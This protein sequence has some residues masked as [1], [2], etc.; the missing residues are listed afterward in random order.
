MDPWMTL[1]AAAAL[2]AGA[3]PLW[4]WLAGARSLGQLRLQSVAVQ[5]LD[6]AAIPSPHRG[7]LNAVAG[8][9]A[10]MGFTYGYSLQCSPTACIPGAPWVY[11]D[12]YVSTDGRT[13]LQVSPS[14]LPEAGRAC[15]F[16]WATVWAD[17]GPHDLTTHCFRHFLL[18]WTADWRV[19]DDYLPSLPQA[20][21]GHQRRVDAAC[22]AG[23]QPVTDVAA[24]RE[25]C[26]GLWQCTVPEGQARGYLVPVVPVTATAIAAQALGA[27]ASAAQPLWRIRWRAALR[28]APALVW[29]MHRAAKA[30]ARA[31]APA[32][33]AALTN[34]QDDAAAPDAAGAALQAQLQAFEQ[35]QSYQAEVVARPRRQWRALGITAA[36]FVLVGGVLLS[37]RS[38]LVLLVVIGLHEGGHWLA[39]RAL[40][41]RNLS[42]LFIPGLG[43]LAL[44][45][46]PEASTWNKLAVYLAGPLPGLLL[47]LAL[48]WAVVQGRLP[49][50][51]WLSDF[52][53]MCF[54]I[55]YLNLLPVHPLDGGRVVESL[56]F[57]RWPVLRFVFVLVG[58]LALAAMGWFGSD[59]ITLALAGLLAVGLPHHW[60]LMCVDRQ[61]P[62]P[63]ARQPLSERD[64][65]ARVFA[66][67]LQPRFARWS[68]AQR[69]GAVRAL[70]PELQGTRLGL[71]GTIAGLALYLACLGLPVV[72]LVSSGAGKV[73]WPTLST[74]PYLPDAVDDTTEPHPGPSQAAP[75]TPEAWEQRLMKAP[76]QS[77]TERLETYL[78]AADYALDLEDTQAA[79]DRYQQAWTLAEALPPSD[80]RR[81]RT[82]LGLLHATED[83]LDARAW[84]LRLLTDL[85]AD[86]VAPLRAVRARAESAL[87]YSA[88]T[89]PERL[90]RMQRA[91]AQWE[92]DAA[93]QAA[94]A[95]GPLPETFYDAAHARTALSRWLVQRAEPGDADEAR[96]LLQRSVDAWPTP[97]PGDRS[98]AALHRRTGRADAQLDLAW[99]LL[100]QGQTQQ[101]GALARQVLA[102]VPEP[103]TASWVHVQDRALEAQVWVAM[104]GERRADLRQH[105]QA[106]QQ[107]ARNLHQPR[108][109]HQW[110]LDRWSVMRQL[111]ESEQ[112]AQAQAELL[113]GAKPG[114]YWA[115]RW[116]DPA[117][118]AALVQD[119]NDVRDPSRREAAQAT[120]LCARYAAGER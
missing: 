54:I 15:T 110:Q 27:G 71:R 42:V 92:A 43:G 9:L 88:P 26:L 66:A 111:G 52:A 44:G 60:R 116:C 67:L 72:A 4:M 107:S 82:L 19:H 99:W 96:R 49:A 5:V 63:V 81:A 24:V 119:A 104:A 11:S 32:G 8:E 89:L 12:V 62:R 98:R 85:P 65:A 57:V 22:A 2:L 114:A 84:G 90:E 64:A 47:A 68:F 103:V 45:H 25:A 69:L 115:A 83:P 53:L 21:A 3:L 30:V 108:R 56:L 102:Q 36:L 50:S 17:G 106:W 109:D 120:G 77:E 94:D 70:L 58:M 75:V 118:V 28:L 74:S 97:G 117:L 20:W 73:F 79:L 113:R 46:K 14:L 48:A 112:A 33:A 95:P 31:P 61:V 55:N 41:Y 16:Q 76:A 1:A 7:I 23:R 100:A 35:H 13:Q 105:W 101:A 37:W 80:L 6:R 29:G 59:A 78:G 38:A 39:M 51:P 86:T 10:A 87:A 18:W 34:F 40:G 91:L 93:A